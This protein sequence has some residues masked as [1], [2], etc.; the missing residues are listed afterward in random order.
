MEAHSLSLTMR[1]LSAIIIL[2]LTLLR[3]F[4]ALLFPFINLSLSH[5]SLYTFLLNLSDLPV[6]PRFPSSFK[7]LGPILNGII[8]ILASS[9]KT[10]ETSKQTTIKWI[11]DLFQVVKM[12]NQSI[13]YSHLKINICVEKQ[14]NI[15]YFY[16]DSKYQ[17]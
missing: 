4:P 15:M 5:Q 1:I 9:S 16:M 17:L 10:E 14:S 12:E 11:Q 2:C 8:Y 6:C 7:L 13:Y 3:P